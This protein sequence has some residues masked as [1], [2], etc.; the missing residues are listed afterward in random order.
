MKG[1]F[2]GIQRIMC[3][4]EANLMILI[5]R[6]KTGKLQ[7]VQGKL[8]L[9]GDEGLEFIKLTFHVPF[10][11]SLWKRRTCLGYLSVLLLEGLYG[12]EALSGVEKGV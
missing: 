1:F 9:F 11:I 2:E 8:V 5:L 12:L 3:V 6:V 10:E 7:E 4:F